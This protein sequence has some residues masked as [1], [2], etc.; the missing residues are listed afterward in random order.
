[1]PNTGRY[2]YSLLSSLGSGG[3]N[4]VLNMLPAR[5]PQE[6]RLFP[7][8]DLA[9]VRDWL[10]WADRNVA[11]LVRY[12]ASRRRKLAN[13]RTQNILGEVPVTNAPLSMYTRPLREHAPFSAF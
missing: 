5:D 3:L 7:K 12:C 4:N 13:A 1:M 2:R 9:F 6:F 11:L 10:A 8:E